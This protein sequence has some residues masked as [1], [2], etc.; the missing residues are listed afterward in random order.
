MKIEKKFWSN[1]DSWFSAIILNDYGDQV[2]GRIKDSLALIE[3]LP[4]ASTGYHFN[5]VVK[6]NKTNC[7]QLYKDDYISEYKALELYCPSDNFTFQFIAI[8]SN[9]S[10]YFDLQQWFVEN[11]QISS[12]VFKTK[13]EK[14]EW[15]I[16]FCSAKNLTHAN[17]MLSDF[18]TKVVGKWYENIIG[19]KKSKFNYKELEICK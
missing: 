1:P 9:T 10:E 18:Q 6:V 5:D 16:C 14:E 12:L 15:N 17:T 4:N 7:Q 19:N 11:N 3:S 2:Y 13:Y 8:I